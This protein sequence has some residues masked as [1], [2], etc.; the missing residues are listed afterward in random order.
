[1]ATVID[2]LLSRTLFYTDG[3]TTVWDFS[4][5][6]GYLDVS[7]VKAHVEDTLGARIPITVLPSMLIGEY[8]LEI[9]PALTAGD[10]LTIYRDTPKDLPLVDFTDESGFS[11]A[12]L[13]TN[14]KQAVFIAAEAADTINTTDIAGA[15]EASITA[16]D[17]ADAATASASASSAS[18]LAASIYADQAGDSA[19][20]AAQAVAAASAY[21]LSSSASAVESA[22]S[23]SDAANAATVA[24]D[25]TVSAFANGLAASSGASLVGYLPAGTGAVATDVQSKLRE[26]V[27]VFDFGAVGDWNGVTGTDDT[28]AIQAAIDSFN[29]ARGTVL[30]GQMSCRCEAARIDF[31]RCNIVGE[32]PIP[33]SGGGGSLLYFG[34]TGGLYTSLED[35][36]APLLKQFRL[37]SNVATWKTA[38]GQTML[39]LTGLNYPNVQDV[40]ITGG[41]IGLRINKGAT[42][43]SHYGNFSAV[44]ISKCFVGLKVDSG[45]YAQT[46]SFFAG[47]FWDCV[48]AYVNTGTGASDINFYGTAF[49]SEQAIRHE[50]TAKAAQT[51]WFSCRNESGSAPDVPVGQFI[52][53]GTYWSG[54]KRAEAVYAD[55]L[56]ATGKLKEYANKVINIGVN[57]ATDQVA[58]NVLPNP[59]FEFD[60]SVAR[61]ASTVI[62]GWVPF[63]AT[64]YDSGKAVE[65]NY[66]RLE[67]QGASGTVGITSKKIPLKAGKYIFTTGWK[68][69]GYG[70]TGT[71]KIDFLSGGV[72]FGAAGTKADITFPFTYG[73]SEYAAAAVEI[74][75]DIDDFEFRVQCDASTNGRYFYVFNP[76]MAK[77]RRGPVVAP[78]NQRANYQC[79]G[80]AA[81]TTGTWEVGATV[82]NTTPTAGGVMGWVCT[83]AG[84]PGTWK[85]FGAISA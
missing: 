12:S 38:N 36:S 4:F 83:T 46:H 66:I 7:H 11:E 20:A 16:G 13:D 60:P 17:A 71:I 1:M 78:I 84:T 62:P 65:G 76:V 54:N 57:N 6:G 19:A 26:S 75:V 47:R 27:S 80:L 42:I 74:L 22:A 24:A 2:Q 43:E 23:A 21:A 8:Q 81:P 9:T 32:S 14:A 29:G 51:K 61:T 35:N 63:G 39:D 77:G 33:N 70:S 40:T 69:D 67:R 45:L 44:N 79:D 25:A 31:K 52:Q 34:D 49:E 58:P 64:H 18:A 37:T 55:G 56:L 28:A 30:L 59:L 68:K 50:A 72:T 41:E 82:W 5:S 85:T 10:T 3:V 15:I 53:L 73:A 48:D